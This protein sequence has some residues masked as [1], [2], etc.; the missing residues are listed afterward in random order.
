M[1]KKTKKAAHHTKK[2][3]K[4]SP[5]YTGN[6]VYWYGLHI[7]HIGLG[8]AAVGTLMIVILLNQTM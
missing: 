4:R 5:N 7:H 8:V 1:L 6:G 3:V 2:T